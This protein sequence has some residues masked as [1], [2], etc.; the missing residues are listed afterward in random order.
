[1][2]LGDFRKLTQDL[3]DSTLL[4]NIVD[5]ELVPALPDFPVDTAVDEDGAV[6]KYVRCNEPKIFLKSFVFAE[7]VREIVFLLRPRYP[8]LDSYALREHVQK[9]FELDENLPS[10]AVE[11]YRNM[12][13]NAF[14]E[15]WMESMS[16]GHN[17]KAH[18]R[19][20]M[21]EN[22]AAALE[23]MQD[24]QEE[25]DDEDYPYIVSIEGFDKSNGDLITE[26]VTFTPISKPEFIEKFGA[27][28]ATARIR[29]ELETALKSCVGMTVEE[30]VNTIKDKVFGFLPKQS[31]AQVTVEPNELDPTRFN[32]R[33]EYRDYS[34]TATYTFAVPGDFDPEEI[35]KL[36]QEVDTAIRANREKA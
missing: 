19:S 10:H 27:Q 29:S 5:I 8:K 20:Y 7:A 33:F 13:G 30:T 1:M 25:H 35:E 31:K 12:F 4:N 14:N 26:E 24:E 2:R 9:Y 3:P 22:N 32:V 18:E 16:L 17:P 6:V 11:R 23:R 34:P 15:A 36:V 28:D 21:Q